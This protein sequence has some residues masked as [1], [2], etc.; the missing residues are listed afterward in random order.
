MH[1][2]LQSDKKTTPWSMVYSLWVGVSYSGPKMLVRGNRS[3]RTCPLKFTTWTPDPAT[4]MG[5]I[6]PWLH[7]FCN[8]T[9]SGTSHGVCHY[10]AWVS[11]ADLALCDQSLH[12]SSISNWAAGIRSRLDN[13]KYKRLCWVGIGKEHWERPLYTQEVESRSFEKITITFFV[14]Y[15][16]F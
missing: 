11:V 10:S 14:D 3:E 12:H 1:W 9:F 8:F 13:K 16:V 15:L 5:Q 2:L 4:L 7:R 6:L